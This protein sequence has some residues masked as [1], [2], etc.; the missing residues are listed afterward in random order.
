LDAIAALHGDDELVACFSHGDVIRLAVAHYLQMPLNAYHRLSVQTCSITV[1]VRNKEHVA[2]PHINQVAGFEIKPPPPKKE[3][4]KAPA[5][6][7][8]ADPIK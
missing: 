7:T 2:V 3:E 5:A 4:K 1:L 8:E 6:R